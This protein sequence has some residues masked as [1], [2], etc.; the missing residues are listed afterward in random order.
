[1][2]SPKARTVP[3]RGLN[4][5][6]DYPQMR[7]GNAPVGLEGLPLWGETAAGDQGEDAPV[8]VRTPPRLNLP[9]RPGT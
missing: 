7:R 8:E 5:R 3:V 1:M 2:R 6:S 9:N 4:G